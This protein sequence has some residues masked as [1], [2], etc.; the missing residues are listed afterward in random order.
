MLLTP[1]V[2]SI[3]TAFAQVALNQC[4]YN[5]VLGLRYKPHCCPLSQNKSEARVSSAS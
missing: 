2:V 5:A 4:Q 1:S 3:D